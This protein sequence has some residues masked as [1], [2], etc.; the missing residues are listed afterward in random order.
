MTA[1]GVPT[2]DDDGNAAAASAPRAAATITVPP[3]SDQQ[4]DLIQQLAPGAGKTVQGIC[5]AYRVGSLR[6]LTAP[7]AE[8]LIERL[9]ADTKEKVDA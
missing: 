7:Q 8:K 6:D 5:E 3:I 4:R 1:F 2:E 9:R